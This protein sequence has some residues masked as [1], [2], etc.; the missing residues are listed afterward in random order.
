MTDM[1]Y[2]E[3]IDHH[4]P[5]G[6]RRWDIYLRHC[7][8]VARKALDIARAKRLDL[9]EEDIRAA[10]MLHDIGIFMTDAPSIGCHG[11]EPYIC[12]GIIGAKLLRELGCPEELAAVAERHTGAGITAREV[13]DGHLPIPERDYLPVTQLERLICY[14]DKFYSKSGDMQEK[15]LHVVRASLGKISSESL[16]RFDALH[17]EFGIVAG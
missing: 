12:H 15:P 4:Y 1:N 2:Q 6:S 7:G 13:R 16:E 11:S 3:I 9:P 5:V 17:R 14:A 8:Q 10:A